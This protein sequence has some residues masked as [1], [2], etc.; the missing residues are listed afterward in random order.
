MATEFFSFE[1][2]AEWAFVQKPHPKFDP[3][4][5][6]LNFYPKDDDTRRAVKATGL[7]NNVKEGDYGFYYVFRRGADKG[8]LKVLDKDGQ[9]FTELL[10]NGSDVK[11]VME[12]YDYPNGRGGR[13]KAGRLDTVQILN[14]IPYH[15]EKEIKEPADVLAAAKKVPF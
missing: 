10:G 8:P 1:G 4:I 13:S 5:Y 2:K 3:P 14:L 15:P 7:R 12:V 6:M 11:I 9:P